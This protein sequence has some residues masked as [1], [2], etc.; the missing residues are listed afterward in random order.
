VKLKQ[1]GLLSCA[2]CLLGKQ[3]LFGQFLTNGLVAYYPFNGNANDASGNGHDGVVYG[4]TLVADRFGDPASAYS[5]EGGTNYIECA[6]DIGI[7]GNQPR[8]VSVWFNAGLQNGYV[9]GFV[10]WP[11]QNLTGRQSD[12]ACHLYFPEI[13]DSEFRIDQGEPNLWCQATNPSMFISWHH[14]VWTYETNFGDS[15]FYIDGQVLPNKRYYDGPSDAMNTGVGSF[16][17]GAP[18]PEYNGVGFGYTGLLDDVRIYNRALCAAEVVA[19]YN[20]ELYGLGTA[21]T[22]LAAVSGHVFFSSTGTAISGTSV[23]IGSAETTTASDGSYS[24]TGLSAGI[25]AVSVSAAGY[26]TLSSSLTIPASSQFVQNFTLHAVNSPGATPVVNSVTTQYSPNGEA[27]Y[28][29]DGASFPVTFTATVD[30]AGHPPGSVQFIL[31]NNTLSVNMSG[32]TASQSIDVGSA[33]GPGGQLQVQAISGDGASSIATVANFVVMSAIPSVPL[34]G[35]V[36]EGNG[37]SYRS[38]LT[39]DIAHLLDDGLPAGVTISSDIPLF[40]GNPLGLTYVPSLDTTITGN[41]LDFSLEVST[42]TATNSVLS[43]DLAAQELDLTPQVNIFGDYNITSKQWVWGGSLGVQGKADVSDT[44]PFVVFAGPIPIPMYAQ[45]NLDLS[46]DATLTLSC[47]DPV[48]WNGTL[49][50]DPTITGTLAAGVNDEIA[51]GGWVSGEVDLTFQYPNAPHLQN[52]EITISAGVTV[53]ANLFFLNVDYKDQLFTWGWPDNTSPHLLNS[54]RFGK[55]WLPRPYPRDYTKRPYYG[56]F[57]GHLRLT[58]GSPLR[59]IPLGGTPSKL[60][61]NPSLYPLQTDVLPFSES[62]ITASGTNCYAVW[63]Y[64]N[65]NR[66]ANNRAM[67][68]FSKFDGTEWSDPTPVA[69]DGTADFHPQI[70]AFPDGSAVVAWE[71]EGAVL[72]TNADF[73][74]ML[75]NLQIATA[76]YNPVAGQWQPMKQLT[77]NNYLDRSPRIAGESGTNLMLVWVAN[78]NS[79]LEGSDTNIN[80]LWFA[81]WNGTTWSTPQTFA[82]VP[83]PLIKYDLSYDGTNAYVVMSLDSDNTLTN[84]SAHQMFDVAYQKGSWGGLVQLTSNQVPNDDPQMA[85]D[86]YGNI[87]FVWLQGGELSSVVNFNFASRQVAGTNQ[88]SSNLGDFKLANASD[89]RLAIVWAKPSRQYPSDL[90]GMFYDPIFGLWGNPKQLTSDPETELETAATFYNTNQLIALYDRVDIAIGDTN[91]TGSVI[92][93]ADLYVLQYQLMN[94]L[95]LAANS[96]TVSPTNPAPGD[97]VNLS[98][99]AENFGDSGVS[100]VLVEFYQGNPTNGGVEIG[101]TNLA[102][103]L[104]PG[105]TDTVSIPWT[106]PATTNPLPIYAVIDPNQQFS[107]SDLSNNITSNTVVE[108]DLEVRS[109]TW[110]QIT[111]NLLS[112]TATVVNQGAIASQPATVSLLLNSLTGPNLFWTNIGSLAAGQSIDVNFIWTVTNLGSGL[113]L[114]AVVNGGTDA[115]QMTIQPNITQVNVQFGAVLFLS[116]GIAQIDVAGLAGQTYPIQVSTDLTNWDFLTNIT[117]SNLTGQFIDPSATNYP[118]RFYRAVVP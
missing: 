68:V 66:T 7:S 43:L 63:L 76:F 99:T 10:G 24:I 4:A 90:Y 35:V 80:Q 116:N 78:T 98:V 30:W 3:C 92:T 65:T 103:V 104:A 54:P 21:Q 12:W 19:L 32:N 69:D 52:Y 82:S 17:I 5:F 93:N 29:L 74:A 111:T 85:I 58:N 27:L 25:Y 26:T 71:N 70:K 67:L 113:T 13:I 94:D 55:S 16:W 41:H 75:T 14:F 79:D 77:T 36:Y 112:I 73:S 84:V 46:A 39:P 1:F 45:V 47:F 110:G 108:P 62:S 15:V 88:Y 56:L 6:G 61:L 34:L 28:F 83:Y 9:G 22:P 33:F 53:Y 50:L 109:L 2:V 42:G 114:F 72:S 48:V 100:N 102:I 40:G 91:Q 37:F 31:P 97:T 11:A 118:W 18:P 86:P 57:N 105:A 115:L 23:Q 49:V 38:T 20:L 89:G 64:D 87:V 95:A 107:D 101:Q 8:T 96:L 81:T 60:S 44:W 51:V 117:V 106:V 59:P